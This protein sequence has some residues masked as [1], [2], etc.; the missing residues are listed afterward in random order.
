MRRVVFCSRDRRAELLARG[1]GGQLFL[2]D[3]CF[4]DETHT[5]C[6][7]AYVPPKRVCTCRTKDK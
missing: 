1:L 5:G 4:P 6:L 7:T 3:Q 2:G